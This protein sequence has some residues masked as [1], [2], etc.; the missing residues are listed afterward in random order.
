M[1]GAPVPPG[2]A[3]GGRGAAAEGQ[4][5]DAAPP[6]LSSPVPSR[7]GLT[8]PRR[9]P[10]PRGAPP[11]PRSPRR[12][13]PRCL[14]GGRCPVP[15]RPRR[16]GGPRAPPRTPAG[17]PAPLTWP[18]Q[19]GADMPAA[20]LGAACLP[21]SLP[22]S[23][24]SGLGRAGQRGGRRR[25]GRSGTGTASARQPS[26]TPLGPAPP[27]SA[28]PRRSA[29]AV[30]SR[31]RRRE[32]GAEREPGCR[33]APRPGCRWSLAAGRPPPARGHPAEREA[34]G[35]RGEQLPPSLLA[36]PRGVSVPGLE[37]S[38]RLSR[39]AAGAAG[40]SWPLSLARVLRSGSSVC[41]RHT[42]SEAVR[43]R[44]PR[45][46]P[47]PGRPPSRLACSC[48]LE[49]TCFLVAGIWQTH[50]I[51]RISTGILKKKPTGIKPKFNTA[52]HKPRVPA[53][54]PWPSAA[55][56][57]TEQSV[58]CIRRM[59]SGLL[60]PTRNRGRSWR[61]LK[62]FLQHQ[63]PGTKRSTRWWQKVSQLPM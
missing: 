45:A 13:P 36:R 26:A 24:G 38:R 11:G 59:A 61:I 6:L 28:R 41:R 9:H 56:T 3:G 62:Y 19:H 50:R 57:S 8:V 63:L 32:G 47:L 37:A 21:A 60:F 14:S 43:E 7:P 55:R 15:P 23:C 12:S 17:L 16:R 49:T 58:A 22:P 54:F 4:R 35:R 1:C 10:T 51:R 40:F 29:S 46:V 5:G 30:V 39:T 34:A 52:A 33:G 31:A 48:A 25:G 20:R 27:P 18:A 44:P 2:A 42:R 53:A